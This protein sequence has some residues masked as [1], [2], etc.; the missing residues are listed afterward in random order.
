LLDGIGG[1][2]EG[3]TLHQWEDF[4]A[5]KNA[6]KEAEEAAKK[7]EEEAAESGGEEKT[8]A[9]APAREREAPAGTAEE[10]EQ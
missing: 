2:G 7:A 10:V 3:F 1:L 5:K 4:I 9:D 6:E 8:P